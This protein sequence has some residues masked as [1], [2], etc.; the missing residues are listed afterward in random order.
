VEVTQS[1]HLRIPA[2]LA[3]ARFPADAC[4]LGLVEVDGRPELHMIPLLEQLAG[5]RVIL[6][7]ETLSDD[8]PVG[9]HRTRWDQALGVLVV[10]LTPREPD[11]DDSR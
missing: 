6:V 8:L 7:R 9:E 3:A 2:A 4:G 11:L 10:D 5:D 1:G